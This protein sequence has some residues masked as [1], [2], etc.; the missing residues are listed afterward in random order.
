[1]LGAWPDV[2]PLLV[3]DFNGDGRI[4]A[5]DVNLLGAEVR[6]VNRPE[7]PDVP[8]G[9]VPI[10]GAAIVS[11]PDSTLAAPL[12]VQTGPAVSAA[13]V[14]WSASYQNFALTP[15]PSEPVKT[16]SW[17]DAPWVK[18]LAAR[19]AEPNPDG[20]PSSEGTAAGLLRKLS[21]GVVLR[22]GR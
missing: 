18:D 17:F 13:S 21:R 9:T 14:D 12:I 8:F 19:L 11:Q 10:L 4:N 15:P 2:D 1:V 22:L 7:I 5:M 6:G 16:P 3:A 20:T